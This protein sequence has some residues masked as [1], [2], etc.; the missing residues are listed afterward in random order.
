MRLLIVA[1]LAAVVALVGACG[2]PPDDAGGT[3]ACGIAP[4]VFDPLG[5][6]VQG[7]TGTA[8]ARIERRA[9]PLEEGFLCKACP[10]EPL[11]LVAHVDDRHVDIAGEALS[12]EPSHH[13]WAD[14]IDGEDARVRILFDTSGG[15]DL[16]LSLDD[17]EPIVLP[18]VGSRE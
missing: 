2:V 7:E 17:A 10:Y 13:N 18:V 11:R 15:W 16:E 1:A 6:V 12:Y 4:V 5:D 9:V 14:T 8:C 3:L